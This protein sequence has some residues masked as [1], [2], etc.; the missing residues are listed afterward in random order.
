MNCVR[1][2]TS[3]LSVFPPI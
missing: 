3:I 1:E 2:K